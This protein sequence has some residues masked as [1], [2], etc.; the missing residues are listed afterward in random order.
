[1][2][3][4]IDMY[5]VLVVDDEPIV[6]L[7]FKSLL[8]W[9]EHNISIEYEASNGKQALE[10]LKN[11]PNINM[12]I[13]DINMPIMDGITLIQNIH[14]QGLE[15]SLVVLSSYD[16]YELVRKAFKLGI[17]DY[18][19]KHKMKSN[20]VLALVTRLLS[21]SKISS[22]I[23]QELS[24]TQLKDAKKNYLRNLLL[25][26]YDSKSK[27]NNLLNLQISDNKMIVCS[28]TV[29]VFS[30]LEKQYNEGNLI[31]LMNSATNAIEQILIESNNGEVIH[32]SLNEFIVILSF[33]IPS[34]LLIRHGI[35]MITDKIRSSLR[36]YLDINVTI[37]ISSLGNGI[38][39]VHR[40]L[41]E[42]QKNARLSY[43]LGKGEIIYPEHTSDIKYIP[44]R[45]VIKTSKEM[46]TALSELD[47]KK[48]FE[49]LNEILNTI[50]YF[51]VNNIKDLIVEYAK[52]A[53]MIN[54]YIL[55]LD[56]SPEQFLDSDTNI[57]II[58][59][60]F[61]TVDEIHTW[62]NDYLEQI[63]KYINNLNDNSLN[64]IIRRAKLYIDKNYNNKLTLEN[65]CEYL[66]INESYFSSLFSQNLGIT[67]SN[68]LTKIRLEQA[69]KLLKTTNLKVYEICEQVGY[70]STEHFGR[71]FKKH[72]G[73]NPNKYRNS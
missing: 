54:S 35:A 61:E 34:Q 71:L 67:Y 42:A 18:I 11:K 20:E 47:R 10:I 1:M 26:K 63:F 23:S 14:S 3:V 30:K 27:Y 48:T 37:G 5:R 72:V 43:L 65:I 57:Y 4:G 50:K 66:V 24:T 8:N 44:Y 46:L 45:D 9:E 39:S 55:D 73:M 16:D 59:E 22:N 7:G 70:S 69:K 68:Y 60:N 13:T 6:R 2:K 41:I 51:K 56:I 62:I 32:L 19:L 33:D 49:K 21:T 40:L 52:I 64:P 17:D 29:D 15:L 53:V 28:V 38:K 58:L 36:T 12:V 31:S 25:G